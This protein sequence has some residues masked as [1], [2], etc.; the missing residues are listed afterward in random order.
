L[1]DYGGEDVKFDEL[2]A[3]ESEK[4]TPEFIKNKELFNDDL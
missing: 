2:W 1:G 4:N 3:I